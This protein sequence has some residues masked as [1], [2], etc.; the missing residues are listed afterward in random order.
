MRDVLLT[1]AKSLCVTWTVTSPLA[2]TTALLSFPSHFADC[3]QTCVC[4][5]YIYCVIASRCFIIGNVEHCI[6]FSARNIKN[7]FSI[8]NRKK[9]RI[10]K[11]SNQHFFLFFCGQGK[12]GKL[13]FDIF[14][15]KFKKGKNVELYILKGKNVEIKF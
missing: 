14:V 3:S 1:A 5:L 4:I 12:N 10:A 6:K 2:R 11:M 15:V 9:C 13:Q 7:Y 8:G